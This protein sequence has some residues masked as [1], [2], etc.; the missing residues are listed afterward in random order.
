[1]QALALL[2]R[3]EFRSGPELPTRNLFVAENPSADSNATPHVTV[4]TP[5][6]A[7]KHQPRSRDASGLHTIAPITTEN[8]A[9]SP[10]HSFSS[11][12]S[13]YKKTVDLD[14]DESGTY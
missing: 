7:I 3:L 4:H 2:I 9:R 1:M 13:H 12:D 10:N 6:P 5:A 8:R 11:S 14:P